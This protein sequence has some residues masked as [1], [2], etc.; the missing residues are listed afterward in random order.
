MRWWKTVEVQTRLMG[1]AWPAETEL[2]PERRGE[3]EAEAETEAE[4]EALT[5]N[6]NPNPK[7]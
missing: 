3:A 5:P 6:P 7:S 4:A 1:A 2:D